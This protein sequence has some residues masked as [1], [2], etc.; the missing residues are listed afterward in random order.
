M[1]GYGSYGDQSNE[2]YSKYDPNT[3]YQ[4][5]YVKEGIN[6][7]RFDKAARRGLIQESFPSVGKA[8]RSYEGSQSS[9]PSKDNN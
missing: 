4:R 5:E 9:V 8:M 1:P 6:D 3:D 2:N 7:A